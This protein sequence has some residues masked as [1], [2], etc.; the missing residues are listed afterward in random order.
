[1][2]VVKRTM[3]LM[4]VA[5]LCVGCGNDKTEVVYSENTTKEDIENLEDKWVLPKY[6]EDVLLTDLRN[7]DLKIIKGTA[8]SGFSGD[9]FSTKKINEEEIKV[10]FDTDI[11]YTV[12]IA[13]DREMGEECFGYNL[14]CAYNNIEI[15]T[16]GEFAN[17]IS[18]ESYFESIKGNIP[19][20][21]VYRITVF[22]D[23]EDAYVDSYSDKEINNMSVMFDG[24][25]YNFDIGSITYDPNEKLVNQAGDE[26]SSGENGAYIGCNEIFDIPMNNNVDGIFKVGISRAIVT[27]N[28]EITI[29]DVKSE[30]KDINIKDISFTLDREEQAVDV[31]ME[32][33]NKVSIPKNTEVDM[34]FLLENDKLK[35]TL[36]HYCRI[37]IT[38]YYEIDGVAGSMQIE[39]TAVA[40]QMTPYEIYAYEIDNINLFEYYLGKSSL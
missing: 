15:N 10:S 17:E 28:S 23:L 32:K 1:M 40:N 2:R 18:N 30:N 3:I 36:G 33:G 39:V 19:T 24:K 13:A 16:S 22:M 14:F 38:V 4:L 35:D 9:L 29:T 37:P 8:I 5:I 27:E 11:K 25:E 20:Y 6:M 34:T 12:N 21:Y 31:V 26:L 7:C